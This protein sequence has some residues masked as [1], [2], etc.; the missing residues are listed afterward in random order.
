MA[1]GNDL[2][3]GAHGRAG[4]DPRRKPRRAAFPSTCADSLAQLQPLDL[5][6]STCRAGSRATGRGSPVTNH[7]LAQRPGFTGEGSLA[8]AFLI[9]T[10]VRI[11]FAVTYSKQTRGT[12]SNR[13]YFR[14]S[15]ERRGK[16]SCR[17]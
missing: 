14:G 5:D 15:S 3:R 9:D 6:V 10:K 13:Y 2:G 17:G 12:N 11:E 1:D 8:T 4:I 7:S 16:N